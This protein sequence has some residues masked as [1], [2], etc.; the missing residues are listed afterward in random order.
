[1]ATSNSIQKIDLEN[2][3]LLIHWQDDH[4]SEMDLFWLRDNC[5]CKDCGDRSVGQKRISMVQ[6]PL[7]PE[8]VRHQ[9]N[10]NGDLEITW[11]DQAHQSDYAAQWLRQHC[12]CESCR[13]Q[14]KAKPELWDSSLQN[15]L[16]EFDHDDCADNEIVLLELLERIRDTGFVLVHGVPTNETGFEEMLSRIGYLKE[17]NYGRICDLKVTT[18]GRLLGE[19]NAPIPLHTDECYRHAN[20]GMLAFHCLSTS[21]DGGGANLLADGF[22]LASVLREQNK[23]AFDLLCEIPMVSRR[24]HPDEVDLRS[25]S[26]VISVDF[27]GSLQGVR[28]NERSAAPMD[29]PAERVKPAYNAL[30]V[31]LTLT[32]DSQ[33]QVRIHLK[34]GDMLVFDNQRVLH[35]RDEFNG[36]RHLLYTQLDLD[37]PHSRSRILGK[38]LKNSGS[39][40]NTHRGT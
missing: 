1:M 23:E 4:R 21:D 2:N 20:P 15:A 31:W 10:A 28:Y 6:M 19:T 17:N 25:A 32:R 39:E 5:S 33:Y 29:L 30:K 26:P 7:D 3:Q 35:G 13:N 8:I 38:R 22:K 12:Y 24:F 14:R 11:S 40:S 9:I 37:E 34:P 18:E 16:P 36:N 27:E